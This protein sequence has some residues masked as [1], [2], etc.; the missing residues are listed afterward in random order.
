[1]RILDRNFTINNYIP[2][3]SDYFWIHWI[4]PHLI[5]INT[6]RDIVF[7]NKNERWITQW[8]NLRHS[9]SILAM[10]ENIHHASIQFRLVKSGPAWFH[11]SFWKGWISR[12]RSPNE[13]HCIQKWSLF[14][15]IFITSKLRSSIPNNLFYEC[16]F[17]YTPCRIFTRIPS[18]TLR[19][20]QRPFVIFVLT[21]ISLQVYDLAL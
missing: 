18:K 11:L 15:D 20:M 8:S 17:L 9:N 10:D 5:W 2:L 7:K 19:R 6:S 16:I 12:F 21:K 3:N 14:N 13:M 1:M 4:S